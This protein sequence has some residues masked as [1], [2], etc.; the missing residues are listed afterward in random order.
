MLC[1]TFSSFL[2]LS[3]NDHHA[4]SCLLLCSCLRSGNRHLRLHH[5]HLLLLHLRLPLIFLQF[6]LLLS[7]LH[8][9]EPQIAAFSSPPK[10]FSYLL[11]R[12]LCFPIWP[13]R[14]RSRVSPSLC[15]RC[16]SKCDYSLIII[17]IQIASLIPVTF[18]RI[19]C[20]SVAFAQLCL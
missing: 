17:I 14:S 8:P 6:T 7:L 16:R 18:T 1:F 4:R 5:N 3:L 15:P 13:R 9:I 12:K 10:D 20:L 19:L 11:P 2:F